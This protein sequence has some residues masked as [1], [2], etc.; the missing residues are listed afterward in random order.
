MFTFFIS[1]VEISIMFFTGSELLEV[2]TELY[3]FRWIY[4]I[5]KQEYIVI[6]LYCFENTISTKV[7]V[8][9]KSIVLYNAIWSEYR[10]PFKLL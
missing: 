5:M 6:T 2:K 1:K 4:N 8:V 9:S 10:G 7:S 3:L